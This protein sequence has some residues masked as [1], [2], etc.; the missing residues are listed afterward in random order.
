MSSFHVDLAGASAFVHSVSL[1]RN[2]KTIDDL[3][4]P[5]VKPHITYLSIEAK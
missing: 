3:M 5:H 4:Q 1:F 2:L